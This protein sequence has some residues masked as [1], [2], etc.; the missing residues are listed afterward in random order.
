MKAWSERRRTKGEG[1]G[2]M[3]GGG[4]LKGNFFLAHLSGSFRL[5]LTFAWTGND[6]YA[7]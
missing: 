7:S 2:R 6:Y 3:G 4:V 5:L 1:G